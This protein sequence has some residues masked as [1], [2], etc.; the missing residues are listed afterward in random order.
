MSCE[1]GSSPFVNSVKGI[2]SPRRMRSIKPEVRG[3]QQA[4]VLRVLTVNLF[5]AFGDNELN[6]RGFFGVRCRLT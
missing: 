3:G 4:D 6:A 1:I 2:S 5:N